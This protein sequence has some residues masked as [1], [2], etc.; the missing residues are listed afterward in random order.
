M[1]PSSIDSSRV[2]LITGASRGLGRAYAEAALAAGDRVAALSRSIDEPDSGPRVDEREASRLLRVPVDVTDRAA[3]F[4]AVDAV[5]D[6]YGRI[7]VVVNNAG[8]MSSGFVEEFSEA[9]VRSQF[10]TNFFGALWV[11]QA[12]APVLRKQRGGRLIQVSSIGG[13]GAFPT[14]GVYSASKFAL[15]GLSEALAAEL[16]PFG[17]RTTILEPGGYW[18]DLFTNLLVPTPIPAYDGA[19]A[20]LAAQFADDS[21]DSDPA[22]AAEAL[23]RLVESDDPP[24]R[25]ILG[26]TVHDAAV[27]ITEQRLASWASWA[28][29]SR[30]A[31]RAIV[32]PAP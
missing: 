30:A 25:L 3:V 32:A 2:W 4:A 7:D 22:L 13:I 9:E 14:T 28:E 11:S 16:A 18:T 17:V 26:G 10:E 19:R 24:L 8:T 12:V 6:R 1:T 29:V 27:W 23:L 31:E 20:A 21:V 15:E 5:L